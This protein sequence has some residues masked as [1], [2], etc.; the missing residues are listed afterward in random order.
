MEVTFNPNDSKI[1]TDKSEL[2]GCFPTLNPNS[3]NFL[4]SLY[5]SFCNEIRGTAYT[6]FPPCNNTFRAAKTPNM[7]LPLAVGIDMM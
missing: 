1:I 2:L 3:S 6:T 4:N 5:F 7:V